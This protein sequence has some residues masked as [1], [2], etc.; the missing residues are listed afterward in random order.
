MI[1]N[2]NQ[3]EKI[4]MKKTVCLAG[5]FDI[6]HSGHVE[7]LKTIKKRF[8][9]Y[10]LVVAVLPDETVKKRKGHDRPIRKDKDRL[11]VVEAIKYV[12]YAFVLPKK[13][14]KEN[15]GDVLREL[16]PQIMFLTRDGYDYWKK[17]ENQLKTKFLLQPEAE[18]GESST[19]IIN[20]IKN[21]N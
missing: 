19:V 21:Q 6:F 1:I 15:I 16:R 9:E 18:E 4:R 3:L 8:P 5:C 12:D 11:R 2:F 13:E 20:K 14:Q 10:K 7:W 17:K